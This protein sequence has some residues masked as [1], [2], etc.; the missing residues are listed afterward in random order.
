MT[1]TQLNEA[2]RLA[3]IEWARTQFHLASAIYADTVPEKIRTPLLP[4][5]ALD[6]GMPF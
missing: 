5:P 1:L 2:K 3:Q 6:P 4:A